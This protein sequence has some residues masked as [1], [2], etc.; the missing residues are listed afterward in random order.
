M[1]LNYLWIIT[2]EVAQCGSVQSSFLAG[3][4]YRPPWPYYQD[5][6]SPEN[7]RVAGSSP[8]STSDVKWF[9]RRYATYC[10]KHSE[11]FQSFETDRG[12]ISTFSWGIY[13]FIFQCHRTIEKLEKQHFIC[14]FFALFIVPFFLS[15][16]LFF[17]SFF[18]FPGGGGAAVEDWQ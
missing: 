14:N 10:F 17:L 7:G 8:D 5:R 11:T 2:L 18:L 1:C 13:F 9:V 12:V 3:F 15:F 16:Y 4:I 6:R